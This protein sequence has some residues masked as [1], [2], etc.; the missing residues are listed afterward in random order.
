MKCL[1]Y[2]AGAIGG[3]LGAQWTRQGQEVVLLARGETLQALQSQGVTLVE[4]QGAS[5][6]TRV[7]AIGVDEEE[8]G[9]DLIVVT[10]KSMQ[11]AQAAGD[12]ARRLSPNGVLLMIQNGLPWWY[13]DGLD[14]PWRDRPLECLDPQGVLRSTLPTERIVGATIAR[15]V[16]QIGPGSYKVPTYADAVLRVGDVLGGR[17]DRLQRLCAQLDPVIRCEAVPDIRRAK[18]NKLMRNLVWNT[19]CAI[20]QSGP[21]RFADIPLGQELVTHIIQEGLAVAHSVGQDIACDAAQE[22]ISIRGDLSH[23]PSMLQDVRAGRA[24]EIDA[25]VNSVIEIGSWTGVPTPTLKTIS[26]LLHVLQSAAHGRGIG[27]L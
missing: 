15:P 26:A 23:T 3:W 11:L 1:I 17:S 7:K 25:I 14:S 2:G 12:I 27:L 4:G 13:F 5:Q 10:L 19:L 16:I 21:G 9:F 18:W 20:G 6:S 24:L 8:G 22:L